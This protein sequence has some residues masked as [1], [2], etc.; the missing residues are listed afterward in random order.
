MITKN[1]IITPLG[2]DT[3]ASL[4]NITQHAINNARKDLASKIADELQKKLDDQ[5]NHI[6]DYDIDSCY[7]LVYTD[8][9]EIIKILRGAK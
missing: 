9:Q 7:V 4:Y 2:H 5:L 1:D 3:S 6:K 8:I